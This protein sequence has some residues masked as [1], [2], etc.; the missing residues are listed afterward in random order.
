MLARLIL[1]VTSEKPRSALKMAPVILCLAALLSGPLSVK[2]VVKYI[3]LNDN[4]SNLLRALLSQAL[5]MA[6]SICILLRR[7]RRGRISK[8]KLEL[9]SQSVGGERQD[10]D[11]SLSALRHVLVSRTSSKPALR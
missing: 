11:H 9:K 8:F 4:I 3:P 6:A 7:R 10:F 1:S 2:A 5:E